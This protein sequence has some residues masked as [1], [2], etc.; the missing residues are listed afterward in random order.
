M[1]LQN[2]YESKRPNLMRSKIFLRQHQELKMKGR[3]VN[4]V[5]LREG[6]FRQPKT[7]HAPTYWLN[8][9]RAPMVPRSSQQD[10]MAGPWGLGESGMNWTG[11]LCRR[12]NS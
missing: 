6:Y 5:T 8:G 4:C 1:I 10:G 12:P 3:R 2:T 9:G 7:V 11:E